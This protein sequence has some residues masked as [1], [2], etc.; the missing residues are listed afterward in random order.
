VTDHERAE[1]FF[2]QIRVVVGARETRANA[3]LQPAAPPGNHL[4]L[5]LFGLGSAALPNRRGG[6]GLY[7]L[8]WRLDNVE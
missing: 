8:A 1:R 5:G 6:I 2:T 3:A 7:H 4:D